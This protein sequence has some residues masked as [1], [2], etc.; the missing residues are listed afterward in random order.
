MIRISEINIGG[1]TQPRCEIDEA[2]VSEYAEAMANGAEFPPIVVFNDGITH[3]LADGFHRTH[4]ARR[5]GLEEIAADVRSGTKR[6]AVL[7]SVGA[8]AAH[9]KRRTNADKRKAVETLLK[10]EEWSQWS[11]REIARR[12]GV[13]H[14]LVSKVREGLSGKDYQ[15]P[16]SRK[17]RRNGTAYQQNTANIGQRETTPKPEMMPPESPETQQPPEPRGVGLRMAWEAIGILSR[18]PRSDDLRA[19]AFDTVIDWI[20]AN[21]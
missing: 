1:G 10:D 16:T 9:G 13:T 21:R 14:P 19:D 4:A 8:N 5:A 2:L 18:I 11:D 3:W 15:M 12:C 17:V 6:D 7:F 20:N